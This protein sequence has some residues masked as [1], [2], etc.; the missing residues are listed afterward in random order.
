MERPIAQIAE[1]AA[2]EIV[3]PG[4][5]YRVDHR[6]GAVA[7]RRA[8]VAGLDAELLERIGERE[9]LVLLEVRVGMAPAVPTERHPSPLRPRGGK[10]PSAPQRLFRLPYHRCQSP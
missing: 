6:A 3:G 7:L 8:V 2:M 9:R 4:S 1:S 5:R 10:P